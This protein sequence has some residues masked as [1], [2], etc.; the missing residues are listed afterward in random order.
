MTPERWRQVTAIFHAARGREPATRGAFL[1]QACGGDASLRSEIESLLE[2]QAEATRQGTAVIAADVLP[3]LPPGTPF[4]PYRIDA[5]VGSGGMGQVYRAT[6]PRLHRTVAI[7]V[8]MPT[9]VPDAEL[10]A[11]FEREARLLAALNHPN[12][13]A[14]HGLETTGTIQGL[15]LEFVDGETLG[16]RLSRGRLPVSEALTIARQIA[17]ALEA[18]HDKGIIHRDLKPSNVKVTPAGVVKVLDFGIARMAGDGYPPAA[19]TIGQTGT[20]LILGTPAYM[21]PEQARGLPIDKRTDVWA[22]GCVL[23]EMLTGRGAFAAAT[24]S[25]SV[26]RILEREPEW[27]S[28]PA[29]V[30]PTIVRL[31]KRCLQKDATERLRDIGDAR[32]ESNDAQGTPPPQV[33]TRDKPVSSGRR[34]VTAIVAGIAVLA[35]ATATAVW[36]MRRSTPPA[37]STPAAVEFG[38][39]FPDNQLPSFGM[40]LSPDGKRIAA[41]VFGNQAQIFLHSL[42][43]SDTRP[44]P[45]TEGGNDPFW[46]P[47]SSMVAFHQRGQ[48]VSVNPDTGAVLTITRV[49]PGFRGG[50]WNQDGV[51]IFAAGKIYRVAASGGTPVELP[52]NGLQ[53]T[54]VLPTF[55]PDGRHFLFT[56]WKRN[57]GTAT[58]GSLDSGELRPLAEIDAALSFAAPDRILFLRGTSIVAQ[59]LDLNRLQL[60]GEPDVVASGVFPGHLFYRLQMRVNAAAGVLAYVTS[61]GGSVGR[62]TWFDR[63][64]RTTGTIESPQDVE[65]LNPAIAPDGKTVAANRVD[66]QTGDWDVWLVDL[67]RGVPSKFTSGPGS[68]FDPAWSPDAGA[69]VYASDRSNQLAFYRQTIGGG[70]PERLMGF[71]QSEAALP[72]DWVRT[73]QGDYI[74]Y[75]V[76]V[77]RPWSIWA[78]PLFGDRKPIQL[79]DA[80][81]SP[82]AGHVSPDGRWLA[83]NSFQSGPLNVFVTRFLA[84]AKPTQVTTGG[85]V[86]PRWTRGG[87]E[88]VYWA[89]PDR[90]YAVD[91]S[92]TGTTVQPGPRRTMVDHP[93][94]SLIDGRTHYDVTRDGQRF[95]VRQPAGPQGP[96]I[97]VILNWTS[98]LRS[99]G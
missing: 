79:V 56:Q 26:A 18:A 60:I 77:N 98:K 97:K 53:G 68:N 62:M 29:D 45:G 81:Y 51:I 40:A 36:W 49:P 72:T 21:S 93:V 86:H 47:D 15:V 65:Y 75:Q 35:I 74:L 17:L 44:L 9:L 70:A 83:Y 41:G 66:S 84:D 31:L 12:I 82:Y 19:T 13:A 4:G 1:D 23:Y 10:D 71:G 42:E 6:D 34:A 73:P 57:N 7:K 92:T 69:I 20:G 55:L 14:I 80:S 27:P 61:L 3:Q 85:G 5:L 88:L 58:V 91:I 94:L 16:E 46:S 22:F 87:K 54:A 95:L 33:I 25:D 90:I 11:R 28:L 2:A 38:V 63:D 52:L 24:A 96:G 39:R 78:L 50:S 59:T 37:T 8:L 89:A 32:I 67:A 99:R 64:G 43:T 30:P 48:L 76:S